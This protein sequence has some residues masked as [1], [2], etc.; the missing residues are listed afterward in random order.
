[1]A[2]ISD[3]ELEMIALSLIERLLAVVEEQKQTIKHYEGAIEGIKL[4]MQE[5]KKTVETKGG[6]DGKVKADS[7]KK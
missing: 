3:K 1:M 5:L 7:H 2:N 4:F 6:T